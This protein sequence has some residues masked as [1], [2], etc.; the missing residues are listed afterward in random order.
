MLDLVVSTLVF[1]GAA[2]WLRR[3][4]DEQGIPHGMTRSLMVLVIATAASFAASSLLSW[5]TG[6]PTADQQ[7]M[8]LVGH[9]ANMP[10]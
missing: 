3:Y 8:Q 2:W 5:L 1:F 6:H 10:H 7:I 4:L 9:V